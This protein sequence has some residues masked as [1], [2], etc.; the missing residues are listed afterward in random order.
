MSHTFAKNHLHVVFST[1]ERRKTIAK[2][3]QPELWKYMTGTCRHHNITVMAVGGVEDHAHILFHLPATVALSKAVQ[4]LKGNTSRWMNT[5]I[6]DFA[7]QEGFGAFS[8]SISNTAAVARYIRNQEAH[9]RKMTFE[10]E[11]VGFLKRHDIEYDPKYVF[12]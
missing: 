7:W 5:Q 2:E 12:G 3:L 1:R 6:K 11:Y 4:V 8:V 10:E 9:H